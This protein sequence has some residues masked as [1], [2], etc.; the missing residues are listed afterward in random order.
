MKRRVRDL[1][2]E[3]EI[4]CFA[5]VEHVKN[6]GELACLSVLEQIV[7][8]QSSSLAPSCG[9]R[10]IN[11]D[12]A[13]TPIPLCSRTITLRVPLTKSVLVLSVDLH[14]KQLGLTE[15]EPKLGGREKRDL[16][17]R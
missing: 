12:T 7:L 13:V 5:V 10:Y 17:S 9:F 6:C 14:Q 11:C 16:W 15:K 3:M 8:A 1:T 4:I 2:G